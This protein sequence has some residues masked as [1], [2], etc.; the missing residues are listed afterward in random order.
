MIFQITIKNGKKPQVLYSCAAK[1]YYYRKDYY[2]LL[3]IKLNLIVIAEIQQAFC[4][5]TE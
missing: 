1:A 3:Y 4:I 2:L 5:I